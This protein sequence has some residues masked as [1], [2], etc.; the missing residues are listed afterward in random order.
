MS[1]KWTAARRGLLW[2]AGLGLVSGGVPAFA[3]AGSTYAWGMPPGWIAMQYLVPL[4]TI[5]ALIAL[6][7]GIALVVPADRRDLGITISIAALLVAVAG[8]LLVSLAFQIRQ[9]GLERFA[10]RASDPVIDAIESYVEEHGRAPESLED[11]VPAYLPSIPSTG[12]ASDTSG[13]RYHTPA[14]SRRDLG[15]QPWLLTVS[16]T[17]RLLG[18]DVL[19][20]APEP[21]YEPR[22]TE[23]G[24]H[25]IGRWFVEGD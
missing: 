10:T 2:G 16:L 15:T 22:P 20:F 18:H 17:A 4:L 11:L 7:L 24:T 3:V 19:I 5:A 13:Y 1:S 23:F 21:G 25:R 14:K 12:L 6:G 8:P 9:V